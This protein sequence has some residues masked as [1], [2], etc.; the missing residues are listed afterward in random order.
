MRTAIR[1]RK[2]GAG[3]SRFLSVSEGLAWIDLLE[4]V[5]VGRFPRELIPLLPGLGRGSKLYGGAAHVIQDPATDGLAREF[6]LL[7]EGHSWRRWIIGDPTWSRRRFLFHVRETALERGFAVSLVTLRPPSMAGEDLVGFSQRLLS[8]LETSAFP[9][10]ALAPLLQ[11]WLLEMGEAVGGLDADSSPSKELNRAIQSSL[12]HLKG[13]GAQLPNAYFEALSRERFQEAAR[14]L[15]W[16]MGRESIPVR[17]ARALG[18]SRKLDAAGAGSLVR[19]GVALL[20]QTGHPGWLLLVDGLAN[21]ED[22]SNGPEK[23]S[24]A[25]PDGFLKLLAGGL[26]PCTGLALAVDREC[27]T[28]FEK[29]RSGLAAAERATENPGT[30]WEGQ[31]EIPSF[32]AGDPE[33]LL[34]LGRRLAQGCPWLRGLGDGDGEKALQALFTALDV[35]EKNSGP[36]F[37]LQALA[38]WLL[39]IRRGQNAPMGEAQAS[40][41]VAKAVEW[42]QGPFPK[43][44]SEGKAKPPAQAGQEAPAPLPDAIELSLFQEEEASVNEE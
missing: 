12:V 7:A 30:P 38:W 25:I 24:F 31:W 27:F 43:G 33:T 21:S 41:L 36:E 22:P 1:Q 18:L 42:A 35:A 17:Q 16:C 44:G 2:P 15:D 23:P 32:F 37:F 34:S 10:P 39:E 28:A 26:L 8:S 11:V 19:L 40:R 20:R 6:D 13:L 4:E 9:A 3:W 5:R 29:D 14:L